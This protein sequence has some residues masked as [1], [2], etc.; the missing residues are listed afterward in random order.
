MRQNCDGIVVGMEWLRAHPYVLALT[1]AAILILIGAIVVESRSPVAPQDSTI[2][3]SGGTPISGYQSG[4]A[5]GENLSPQ[6][7]AEEVVQSQPA[8][9]VTLPHFAAS[10]TS[11]ATTQAA[12]S[13]S[14]NYLTLLT[15]LSAQSSPKPIGKF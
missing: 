10:S 15:E 1:G 7:I 6:Q 11:V 12:P 8:E 4:I 2:T 3:W 5:T 9:N 13:G 14:F